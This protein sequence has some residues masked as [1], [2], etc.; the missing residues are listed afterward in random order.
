MTQR[1]IIVLFVLVGIVNFLPIIGLLGA[2][3]LQS[4]YDVQLTDPNLILLMRH[5]AILFG[6]IGG[7]IIWSAFNPE[8]RLSATV[9]GLVSMVS[10]I[11]LILGEPSH[12]PQLRQ[13][14]IIDIVAT[15]I[16]VI[17]FALDFLRIQ[18]T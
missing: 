17:A 13:I 9:I 8:L 5:R 14:F 12:N 3:R 10:F 11:I 16:L 7:Y 4:L 15:I 2:S 1:I 18:M 6:I